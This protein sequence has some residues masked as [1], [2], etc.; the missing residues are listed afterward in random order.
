MARPPA[1]TVYASV[2][3]VLDY[4]IDAVWAVAGR[5]D[6]LEAW[7]DGVSACS[8]E[9]EG[10]GSVRT[11]SRGGI[12]REQ[13]QSCDPGRHQ[14]RYKILAPHALPADEVCGEITL[15]AIGPEATEIVWRSDAARFHAPPEAL[16]ERIEA[17]YRASIR[18]LE[19][20][21]SA[22]RGFTGVG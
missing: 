3:A 10:V 12:V 16:G 18:G 7:A 5:F 11:V 1:R 2:R 8:V 14:I 4:P 20:V 17:F 19:R 6:G 21:L 9:G 13:L 15:R 22:G